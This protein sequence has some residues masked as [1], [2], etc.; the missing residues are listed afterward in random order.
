ML[1]LW[2]FW[3]LVK[4]GLSR[5]PSRSRP[6]DVSAEPEV[7]VISLGFGLLRCPS[8]RSSFIC[9]Y[10]YIIGGERDRE[11]EREKNLGIDRSLNICQ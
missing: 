6:R 10:I 7:A 4:Q 9:V 1:T 2:S 3:R 5:T 8:W 11:R